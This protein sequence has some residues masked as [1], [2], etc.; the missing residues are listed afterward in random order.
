[1]IWDGYEVN[2]VDG[3]SVVQWHAQDAVRSDTLRPVLTNI[4]PHLLRAMRDRVDGVHPGNFLTR[5]EELVV[6]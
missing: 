6:A 4:T 5:R 2:G 3:G 1:M